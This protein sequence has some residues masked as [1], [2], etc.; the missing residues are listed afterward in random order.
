VFKV[1]IDGIILFAAYAWLSCM[2]EWT[3]RLN[4]HS[5]VINEEAIS[6]SQ[7]TAVH[8][9]KLETSSATNL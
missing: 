8:E 1:F 6:A 4:F 7:A 5:G 9:S 2:V 3:N